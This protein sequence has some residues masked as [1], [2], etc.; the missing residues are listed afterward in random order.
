MLTILVKLGENQNYDLMINVSNI[1]LEKA[2][3]LIIEYIK[4]QQK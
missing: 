4:L 2:A 3:D 1:P